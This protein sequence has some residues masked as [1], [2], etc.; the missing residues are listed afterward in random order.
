[1]RSPGTSCQGSAR[2]LQTPCRRRQ[3]S[4]ASP[5]ASSRLT[6]RR[7]S[8]RTGER[9]RQEGRQCGRASASSC[10][11][12]GR[13][14]TL[15]SWPPSTARHV[16]ICSHKT[17][18]SAAAPVAPT[19]QLVALPGAP[20]ARELGAAGPFR[21]GSSCL[22]TQ[23]AVQKAAAAAAAAATLRRQPRACRAWV[24]RRAHSSRQRTAARPG[25]ASAH[26]R[27]CQAGGEQA[28][29]GVPALQGRPVHRVLESQW[30]KAGA[31]KDSQ[32]QG[33]GSSCG[34]VSVGAHT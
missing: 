8:R 3:L 23:A 22:N 11:A 21:N 6:S 19:V 12:R 32:H 10:P 30:K 26:G 25:Q 14:R 24:R 34:L 16:H 29:Q 33:A 15:Q 4:S 28:V 18:R 7:P 13:R 20:Q 1:M 2:L 31:N 17:Q 9:C 5:L 27:Q